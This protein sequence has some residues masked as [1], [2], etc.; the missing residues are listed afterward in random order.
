MRTNC[1]R[2]LLG[3]SQDFIRDPA[4]PFDWADRYLG[5][6]PR[7]RAV[8]EIVVLG[9]LLAIGMPFMI[10]VLIGTQIDLSRHGRAYIPEQKVHLTLWR[11]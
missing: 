6:L 7:G 2:N 4:L 11:A 3:S 10:Y 5:S 1:F 9:L 8:I